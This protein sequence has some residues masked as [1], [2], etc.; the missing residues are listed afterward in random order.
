MLQQVEK[1]AAS[2]LNTSGSS[3]R[4]SSGN[5]GLS[6]DRERALIASN[7]T[8][9]TWADV[10]N[11]TQITRS[12]AEVRQLLLLQPVLTCIA[13]VCTLMHIKLCSNCAV[14]CCRENAVW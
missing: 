11:G 3:S 8:G 12:P 7:A 4:H 2:K 14:A 9:F 13:S 10:I 1:T 6:A 5:N